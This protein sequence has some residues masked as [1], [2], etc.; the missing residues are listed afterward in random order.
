[1]LIVTV[2]TVYDLAAADRTGERGDAADG[3]YLACINR[4][5]RVGSWS[6]QAGAGRA[7]ETLLLLSE[8]QLIPS[9]SLASRP[10]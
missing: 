7:G 4:T 1:M 9:P 2:N 10:G 8:P 5:A 3:L 6:L